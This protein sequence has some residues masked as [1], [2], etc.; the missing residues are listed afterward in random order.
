ML[1]RHRLKTTQALYS[2]RW[3][4]L[5]LSILNT[6]PVFINL[7]HV[8]CALQDEEYLQVPGCLNQFLS[9]DPVTY[10]CCGYYHYTIVNYTNKAIAGERYDNSEGFPLCE[11]VED[12]FDWRVSILDGWHLHIIADLMTAKQK[13]TNFATGPRSSIIIYMNLGTLIYYSA[14]VIGSYPHIGIMY[15]DPLVAV[16]LPS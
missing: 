3:K 12:S 7:N 2:C 14:V 11:R 1:Y 8:R 5:T 6:L 10:Q 16:I 9:W 15:R 4:D 13:W